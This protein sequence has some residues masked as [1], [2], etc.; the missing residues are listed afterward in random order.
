MCTTSL[1]CFIDESCLSCNVKQSR[2]KVIQG[3]PEIYT[4]NL[5]GTNIL[6]TTSVRGHVMSVSDDMSMSGDIS[7]SDDMSVS[8]DMS[9]LGDMSMSGDI[10]GKRHESVR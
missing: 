3:I 8:G 4:L 1:N 9:V 5:Q 6:R 7:V 2:V 10:S